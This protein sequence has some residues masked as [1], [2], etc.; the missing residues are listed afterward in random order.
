MVPVRTT[1]S[2]SCALV[3]VAAT[4]ATAGPGTADYLRGV[5]A[6]QKGDAAAATAALTKA[7][8][9]ED[10]NPDG[11][12][13]LGVANVLGEQFPQAIKALER[14][15]R[16][17]EGH[18][19]TRLWLASAYRM[20]GN[21]A[22]GA[23]LFSFGKLPKDYT[24][25]VYNRMAWDYWALKYQNRPAP[26]LP[27]ERLQAAAAFAERAKA[28]AGASA[29]TAPAVSESLFRRARERYDRQ[30]YTAALEDVESVRRAAPDDPAV[31]NLH[32]WCKFRLN[33]LETARFQFTRALTLKPDLADAF[34][35]RA[36]VA[37]KMGDARRARADLASASARDA[38]AA[39]TLD[40]LLGKSLE[41]W[42]TDAPARSANDL[43]DGLLADARTAR[44]EALVEK[45]I[46]VRNASG[47]NRIRYD[48]AY[49]DQLSALDAARS[50]EPRNPDRIAAE[51]AF[52]YRAASVQRERVG[53]RGE[54][55]LYRY[56][57]PKLQQDELAR[58]ETLADAALAI[59]P[60]NRKALGTKIAVLLWNLRFGEAR[61]PFERLLALGPDGDFEVAMEVV[62][63]LEADASRQRQTAAAL[64]QT[65]YVGE[66]SQYTYWRHPSQAE[67][68][69]ADELDR[70]AAALVQMGVRFLEASARIDPDG[71]EAAFCLGVARRR[72]RDFPAARASFERAVERK[73]GFVE[74]LL[75]LASVCGELGDASAER[76]ARERALNLIQTTAMGPLNRV[77]LL[78]PQTRWGSA[79]EAL[80]EGRRLDPMDPRTAAY[81]G[82]VA[83][84]QN[85]PAEAVAMFRAALAMEEARAKLSGTTFQA[86]GRGPVEAGDIGLTVAVRLQLGELL[87][88]QNQPAEALAAFQ[89]N[90]ALLSRLTPNGL[91]A[92]ANEA[93]IPDPSLPPDELPEVKLFAAHWAWSQVWAGRCLAALKR[94]AEATAAFGI[95]F[96]QASPRSF[97]TNPDVKTLDEPRAWA[98]LE[99]AKLAIA[100]GDRTAARR[101][102]NQSASWSK[103][104]EAERRRLEALLSGR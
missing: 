33:D 18:E 4:A 13:A 51:A 44:F 80:A 59:D 8:T 11:H 23:Q 49:Q 52:L 48:E 104:A 83:L 94:P 46:A 53:P 60:K 71:A 50:R 79:K 35:G 86:D 41:T 25:L 20:G 101:W 3:L 1:G 93:V 88:R 5:E 32:A 56:Q 96:E 66:D 42:L 7:V 2:L 75:Q 45:A 29:E 84:G 62:A 72:Q 37:A 97:G 98:A 74:A 77:W 36:A 10:E 31:L 16:L 67:L 6:I 21:P 54:V 70:K 63:F 68:R 103:P 102:L 55:K 76:D 58:S 64:R 39:R 15:L 12:L 81:L 47:A 61:G 100:A 99:L 57:T 73:P 14:A 34:L 17:R 65:R 95:A 43:L 89:A 40:G 90:I 9:A 24:D 30:D 27:Q 19:E 91:G 78:V 22:K 87:L 92:T 69:E 28:G 85:Q 82:V 26:N 38:N